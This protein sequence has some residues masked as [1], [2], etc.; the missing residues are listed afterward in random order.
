MQQSNGTVQ[1]QKDAANKV[2]LLSLGT[3]TLMKLLE[4]RRAN[5]LNDGA[6]F[7]AE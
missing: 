7:S 5:K 1:E 6:K 2:R 3:S 4:Q